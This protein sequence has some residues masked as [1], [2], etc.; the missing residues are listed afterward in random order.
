MERL[1]LPRSSTVQADRKSI[2][3]KIS[4]MLTHLSGNTGHIIVH[5]F[6]HKHWWSLLPQ[7]QSSRTAMQQERKEIKTYAFSYSW[8]YG[9]AFNDLTI[10]FNWKMPYAGHMLPSVH[11]VHLV[12]SEYMRPTPGHRFTLC[13]FGLVMLVNLFS[14]EYLHF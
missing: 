9:M 5:K 2:A 11:T 7:S 1:A 12:F 13:F 3:K 6:V 10:K 8:R 14:Y 4:V